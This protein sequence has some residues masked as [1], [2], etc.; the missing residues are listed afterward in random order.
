V[1]K[2]PTPLERRL[3][4]GWLTVEDIGHISIAFCVFA[5]YSIRKIIIRKKAD[6]KLM[7]EG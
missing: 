7:G 4:M 6:R 2:R 5:M 3:K 1:H